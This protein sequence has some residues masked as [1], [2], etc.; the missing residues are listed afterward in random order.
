MTRFTWTIVVGVVG[1]VALALL[2]AFLSPTRDPVSDL[3]TPDGVTLAYAL[4]VQRGDL[5]RAWELLAESAKAQTS[6]DRFIARIEGFRSGYQRARLSVEDVRL[7]GE[8]ARVDLV[9]TYP[10]SGGL[11]GLGGAG[12]YANRNTVRLVRE[13]GQWR[14]STPPD[15]FVLERLP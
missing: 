8:S 1:L 15:P 11:L 7:E 12:S 2:L 6:K 4:A 3:S 13:N 14:I 9:R 10:S 5:D